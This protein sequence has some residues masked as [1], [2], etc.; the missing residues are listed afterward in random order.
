MSDCP[1]MS[2]DQFLET[3]VYK[4]MINR[5]GRI[6]A[7]KDV[8]GEAKKKAAEIQAQ[9]SAASGKFD[10]RGQ[11]LTNAE[12]R[13]YKGATFDSADAAVD[14]R[15]SYSTQETAGMARGLFGNRKRNNIF[16][17]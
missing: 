10:E 17:N 11:S 4:K 13:S 9:N 3:G 6:R 15:Y 2:E 12:L 5:F 1:A 8:I 16:G 14:K 7:L